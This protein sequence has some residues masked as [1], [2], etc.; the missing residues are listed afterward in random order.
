MNLKAHLKSC[1]L[2]SGKS[3]KGIGISKDRFSKHLSV[4]ISQSHTFLLSSKT[5]LLNFSKY[6]PR[7]HQSNLSR[8]EVLTSLLQM[9]KQN[10]MKFHVVLSLHAIDLVSIKG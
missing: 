1:K 4:V 10:G 7:D 9:F 3:C 5:L 8:R 2:S 6:K